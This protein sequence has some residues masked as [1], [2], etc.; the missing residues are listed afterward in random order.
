MSTHAI[1]QALQDLCGG[2]TV[3]KT[4]FVAAL[5]EFKKFQMDMDLLLLGKQHT[6]CPACSQ[7]LHS[8]HT[9]GMI[10][11]LSTHLLV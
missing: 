3:D 7:R 1:R 5:S 10:A 9:D 4:L 6:V 2:Q 8:E 11:A